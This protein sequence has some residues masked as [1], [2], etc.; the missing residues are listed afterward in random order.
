MSVRLSRRIKSETGKASR[1]HKR[2]SFS[3]DSEFAVSERANECK[4]EAR[5]RARLWASFLSRADR[6]PAPLTA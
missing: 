3:T 4:Y 2:F 1:L 5:A 6:M